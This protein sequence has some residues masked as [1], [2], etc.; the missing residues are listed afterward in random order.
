MIPLRRSRRHQA[1]TLKY[2]PQPYFVFKD[3]N[4]RPK[5]KANLVFL[6]ASAF[7]DAELLLQKQNPTGEIFERSDAQVAVTREITTKSLLV[8]NEMFIVESLSSSFQN[9]RL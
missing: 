9:L 3:T 7:T 5:N 4:N 2:E 1:K 8:M 6:K